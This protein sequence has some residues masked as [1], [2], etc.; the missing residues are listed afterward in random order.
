MKCDEKLF[1]VIFLFVLYLL[2]IEVCVS[3]SSTGALLFLHL[4]QPLD[5]VPFLYNGHD[6]EAR[7][8]LTKNDYEY[9]VLKNGSGVHEKNTRPTCYARTCRPHYAFCPSVCLSV[10]LCPLSHMGFILEK[11]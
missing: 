8:Y 7:V 10:C 1:H 6:N 2:T 4:C 9:K 3:Y 11:A 5:T